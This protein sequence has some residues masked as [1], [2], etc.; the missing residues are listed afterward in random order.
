MSVKTYIS[1]DVA[2]RSL[3]IG[4]YKLK[5]FKSFDSLQTE[6]M[7]A[8]NKKFNSIVDPVLMRVIDINDGT[9]TKDTTIISK[10]ISLKTILTQIDSDIENQI[11]NDTMVIIEF[12]M[13]ANVGAN[14][15]FNMI[16]FHYADKY[17]I[18]IIKPSWKN[19]I[20]LHPILSHS[21]FLGKCSSNYQ[22]N[23]QHTKYNMIYLLTVIDRLD[24]IQHIKKKNLD[25]IAD[26][27]LQ[28][29]A[30][31]KSQS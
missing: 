16:T 3:A 24:M 18:E 13:N 7:I 1:I 17:P 23:K 30:Y 8:T 10:A 15:I 12:Q 27:L 9:N 26:T 29:L 11:T 19:T 2:V 22:A 25:D 6:D 4:V 5:P 28:C 31:H 14:A 21:Q 20:T